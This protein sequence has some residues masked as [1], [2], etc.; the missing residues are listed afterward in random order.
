MKRAREI[1]E[2]IALK[3]LLSLVAACNDA[4]EG[5]ANAAKSVRH[6]D[7]SNWLARISY[8]RERFAVDLSDAISELEGKPRID[9]QQGGI[10]H[11]GWPELEQRLQPKGEQEILEECIL[12]DTGTLKH[13][14]HA[15]AQ[16]LPAS[17]RS[18]VE[19]QKAAV[20]RDL[21]SLRSRVSRHKSQHA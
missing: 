7:L 16:D 10:L 5:Y 13:Y 1:M 15:L 6:Q 4:A 12:G 14:D 9:L 19:G 20:E 21:D 18:I 2:D 17:I 8:E 3:A 11:G